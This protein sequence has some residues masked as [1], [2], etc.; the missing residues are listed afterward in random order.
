MLLLVLQVAQTFQYLLLESNR[1]SHKADKLI[2]AQ[3]GLKYLHKVK[4]DDRNDEEASMVTPF[5]SLVRQELAESLENLKDDKRFAPRFPFLRSLVR[6]ELGRFLVTFGIFGTILLTG[7]IGMML[8]EGWDF[9]DA[10]YFSVFSQSTVG[11]GNLIPTTNASL[12]FVV[13][14]L[15]T[16]VLFLALFL[17]TTAH[18]WVM[19][20]SANC[21]RIE[22]NLRKQH[23]LPDKDDATNNN[24]NSSRTATIGGVGQLTSSNNNSD[25]I[26]SMETSTTINGNEEKLVAELARNDGTTGFSEPLTI[27]PASPGDSAVSPSTTH[28]P[29]IIQPPVVE[30]KRMLLQR[31]LSRR[32]KLQSLGRY[33]QQAS[34]MSQEKDDMHTL[35]RTLH[36]KLE[37]GEVF[38]TH[39]H[40]NSLLFGSPND[41]A[42]DTSSIFSLPT[43]E[44]AKNATSTTEVSLAL[45]LLVEERLAR[46]IAAE[47]A[48]NDFDAELK[49]ERTLEV[50]LDKLTSVADKWYIPA[51][52]RKAYRHV[53]FASLFY[54]GEHD[55]I[56]YGVKAFLDMSPLAFNALFSPF[57]VAMR[58]EAP[59]MEAWLEQTQ[60][61][62]NDMFTSPLADGE[63]SAGGMATI[64]EEEGVHPSKLF[65]PR[66]AVKEEIDDFFPVNQGNATL[67]TQK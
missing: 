66:C 27:T 48:G 23:N 19:F 59:I 67:I 21:R 39:E 10:F 65:G 41:D 35:L 50:T 63:S 52:A 40:L 49:N 28:H 61:Y 29:T 54:T 13:I 11:Y 8:L 26:T 64:A 47:L 5:D 38:A 30:N 25:T 7:T 24:L 36:T 16:N 22:R 14:W 60:D 55:L 17:M 45:R 4:G 20:C 51:V 58:G 33:R 43:A 3:V 1:H 12:W 15:P 9:M 32:E 57:V 31:T 34:E 6:T 42:D 18:Y 44:D 56:K 62:A 2:G 46:I 37:R 53:V